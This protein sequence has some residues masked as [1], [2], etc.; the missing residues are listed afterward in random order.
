MITVKNKTTIAGISE[1]RTKSEA[2]LKSAK[3]HRVVLEKH[4]K[5]VA[6]LLDYKKYEDFEQMLDFAEDYILGMLALQRDQ[7]T[8]KTDYVDIEKW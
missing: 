2:I 4:H 6:V 7:S 8:P 3:D 5:P 1:L